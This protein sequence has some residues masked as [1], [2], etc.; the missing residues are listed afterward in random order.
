MESQNVRWGEINKS[1]CV[2]PSK[3][4]ADE[5][6][7][8]LTIMEAVKRSSTFEDF[9]FKNMNA[10]SKDWHD[11]DS[12][13]NPNIVSNFN[14]PSETNRN[15]SQCLTTCPRSEIVSDFNNTLF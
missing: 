7:V 2:T 6:R 4:N 1:A 11:H 15:D 10:F 12:K 8:Q 13:S 14:I 3:L 9:N 5:Y